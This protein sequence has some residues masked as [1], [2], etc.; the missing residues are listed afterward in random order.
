MTGWRPLAALLLASVIWGLSFG[1]VKYGLPGFDP[2]FVSAFRLGGAALLFLPFLRLRAVTP[3]LA[4]RLVLLGALQYGLMYSLYLAALGLLPAYA[5]AA[6]TAVVPLMV[7]VFDALWNR[8]ADLWAFL[9]APVAIAGAAVVM[10][11]AGFIRELYRLG[12]EDTASP[13]LLGFLLIMASNA[14]FAAGQV[15]YRQ[16]RPRF[17]NVPDH[18]VFGWLFLG[19]AAVAVAHTTLVGSWGEFSRVGVQEALVLIYLAL[20]ASGL[21][22]FL[23]N[24]AAPRVAVGT[25]ATLNN[26][27]VPLAVAISLL[28]FGESAAIGS[29]LLG[30]AAILLAAA[31]AE[32]RARMP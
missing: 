18:A 31:A 2:G 25:L 8:R 15:A 14:C 4:L 11:G 28:V 19:G 17:A 5:I 29:L 1:L 20:I 16:W 6:A 22:F 30:G 32:A 9:L 7:A 3:S 13:I 26:L 23:W 10:G 21:A 24:A 12:T 27:K